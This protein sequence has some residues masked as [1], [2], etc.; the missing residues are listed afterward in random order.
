MNTYIA[1]SQFLKQNKIKV[2]AGD[3]LDPTVLG[4]APHPMYGALLPVTVIE[5]KADGSVFLLAQAS[6]PKC[7]E[8]FELH[9]G[10]WFQKRACNTCSKKARR[11]SGLSEEEK[12]A[13][14]AERDVETAQA[15]VTKEAKKAEEAAERAQLKAAEAQ[16]KVEEIRAAAAARA[17][18]V[19]KVAAEKGV[20][21]SQRS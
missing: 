3:V 11:G 2:E 6:C 21:V 20:A 19:A 14:K 16:A 17:E 1:P 9:P 18:L 5:A 8:A 12:A 15:R 10:D 4:M 13:R 7:G